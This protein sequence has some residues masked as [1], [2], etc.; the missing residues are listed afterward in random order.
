M[1]FHH[2][3]LFF[4]SFLIHSLHCCQTNLQRH[5]FWALRMAQSPCLVYEAIWT[6]PLPTSC[7][8]LLM[9]DSHDMFS[10]HTGLFAIFPTSS[11]AFLC[12]LLLTFCQNV[13]S[14]CQADLYSS[15]QPQWRLSRLLEALSI[16]RSLI[17]PA[18]PLLPRL[19]AVH[20]LP[21]ISR[22]WPLWKPQRLT[23]TLRLMDKWL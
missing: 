23:L 19:S 7:Q 14:L 5:Y 20:L 2:L 9:T 12:G 13:S 11:A 8:S 18:H 21:P 4:L 16:S 10:R 17:P 22:Q 6:Q 15:L 3:S 1:V